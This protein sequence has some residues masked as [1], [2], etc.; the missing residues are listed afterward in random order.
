MMTIQEY[1]RSGNGKADEFALPGWAAEIGQA[2]GW[3][4]YPRSVTA[5]SKAVVFMGRESGVRVMGCLYQ[6]A[7]G[8]ADALAGQV[9]QV[10]LGSVRVQLK[11]CA[12]THENAVA[13]R[14]LLPFTAP[15]VVGLKTSAG[16]GDRL[17]LATPGHIRS[18]RGT[19]L[20]PFFA[21][22]SI[23][24]MTRSGRTPEIVMDDASW[25]VFQ[26][27]WREGFGSDAD[28]LKTFEDIDICA[29]AGFTLYTI[30]PGAHVDNAAH[31][32]DV[33]TLKVKYNV[34]P[35]SVLETTPEET[36]QRYVGHDFVLGDGL[37]ITM[38]EEQ[39]WRA[40]AKYGRA[41]A[42]T[43]RM[44]RHVAEA[45]GTAPSELE[46]SVDET[47]TPTAP[48]E[49]FFVASELK[50]LGLRWSSLAPR[51]IGR[52]EKGVDYIG[53]LAAFEESIRWHA[54][55]ARYCGPYKLSLHSGSDKFSIYPLVVKYTG[56][57]VHLKTAGTSYLEALRAIAGLDPALFREILGFAFE[58]YEEDKASYH[59]SADLTKVPRPDSLANGALAGVL[60][61]FDGRQLLHVTFGSVL[62][63]R[64]ASGGFRFRDR[65][66][67]VLDA[68]EEA[69]YDVIEAHFDKHLAPFA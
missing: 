49:H 11:A 30:D 52:F 62:L 53:D 1:F 21:Q 23:R 45:M 59:V 18:V 27:G 29:A 67:A 42:H 26:E 58:R 9:R 10:A 15:I 63:A 65:L 57:L 43:V 56:D 20:V 8:V 33:P 6:A 36:L 55:I 38:N 24:E 39:L 32:D 66:L 44:G 61:L 22:Q 17:G 5:L 46:I 7:S 4:V 47:E 69:H 60:D 48:H 34:L 13:L 41:I 35:W 68:N 3:T 54:A 50:R 14:S 25:A 64:T 2:T 51:Y 19:G 28:H 16:C 31:T 12:L 40:A 37:R